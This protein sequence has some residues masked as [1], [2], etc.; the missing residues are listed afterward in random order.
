MT[1]RISASLLDLS[2]HNTTFTG[3]IDPL[4]FEEKEMD[5]I[6]LMEEIIPRYKSPYFAHIFT[7]D[8]Y[9]A[10]YYS[11]LWAEVLDA[12]AFNAFKESGDVF[13]PEIA[14]KFRENILSRGG[15]VEPMVLYNQFRG[16]DPDI[17]AL[18]NRAGL[19]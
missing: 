11:Y 4:E 18:L 6:G 16:S 2:W 19:D 8:M 9:S 3:D 5:R 15:T 7:G 13:N 1:E 10:G 12:D 14:A 17:N